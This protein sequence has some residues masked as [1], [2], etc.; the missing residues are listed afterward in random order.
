[1]P[2]YFYFGRGTQPA[3]EGDVIGF[4]KKV[5]GRGPMLAQAIYAERKGASITKGFQGLTRIALLR[6]VA[7]EATRPAAG[8]S[9]S[10]R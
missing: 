5:Y 9:P 1:M 4:W 2:L 6:A 8:P 10:R 7:R 3:F